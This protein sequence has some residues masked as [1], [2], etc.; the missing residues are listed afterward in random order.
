M[1]SG[2]RVP[3]D[4]E[5]RLRELDELG[6][7]DVLVEPV[8]QAIAELAA[9]VCQAPIAL[10]NLVGRDR[11]YFKGHVGT[12]STDMDRRVS[13][14]PHTIE[15]GRLVEV[16]D[17]LAD[18]E[19]RDDP[20]VTGEPYVRFYA[21]APMISSHRHAL[22]V[23]CVFDHRPRRLAPG[24]HQALDT[25]AVCATALLELHHHSDQADKV[26][27][28][29]QE[30]DE[31]KNQFLRTVNH[32]LRT[33]LTSIRSYLHLIQDGGLDQ[34]TEQRFL[35]VIDRNSERIL[36]L[37]DELLL[38]ASLNARTAVFHP[39]RTDLSELARA[40]VE[41]AAIKAWSSSHTLTL[42][43]PAE[44]MTWADAERIRQVLDQLLDNA[45]KFTP[46][47]GRIEVVVHAEPV[48]A[49]EI[50]DNGIGIAPK[51][52]EH[53]FEDFYRAPEAE[54]QAIG[55]TGLG[56]PIVAKIVHMHGGT[57][58]VDSRPGEGTRVRLT[59]P[60]PPPDSG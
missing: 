3:P 59:L 56:L 19:F 10:V 36:S 32:E 20:A 33:P 12:S 9:Y 29:L 37:I 30:V 4:E 39:T 11:Q 5:E 42:D 45:V 49:L 21:G 35:D 31:L 53:I 43:A 47:G 8:F 51:E 38:M 2:M 40:A 57:V 13:F 6:A 23:V 41:A 52:L 58:G 55:G 27:A 16:P 26:I 17:A 14:C 60:Y 25:L 18:P 1:M 44:V 50:R 46:C 24:Q 28:R 48:A 22:G 15:T 7:L 34:A 54:E